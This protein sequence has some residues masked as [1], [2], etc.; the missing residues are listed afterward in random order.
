MSD[1]KFTPG[2]WCISTESPTLIKQD[3]SIIGSNSGVLIGSASGYTGSGYFPTDETAIVNARLMAASPDLLEALQ[4][5]LSEFEERYDLE[6]PSTNPGV[7]VAVDQARTAIAKA[8][9]P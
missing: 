3:M 8:T 1:E 7:K 6:S 5:C 9:T 2:P 4:L